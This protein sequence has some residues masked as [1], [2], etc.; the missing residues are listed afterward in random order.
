VF[1]NAT[2]TPNRSISGS[3]SNCGA[4]PDSVMTRAIETLLMSAAMSVA[5]NAAN[6]STGPGVT[7]RSA[8]VWM[9]SS[10]T[11]ATH[12]KF[13]RLNAVLMRRCRGCTRSAAA[14]PTSIA[15][16]YSDGDSEKKPMTAGNSLREKAWVSRPK[17]TST[18]L[19]SAMANA[20]ASS[21]QGIT[22]WAGAG[23]SLRIP[24]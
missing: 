18:T 5:A 12:R 2:I 23:R 15:T 3:F 4:P 19:S 14:E 20:T 21:G 24:K 11:V 8:K 16:R 17:W 13:A 1:A 7:V 9:M 6:H 22:G 10:D